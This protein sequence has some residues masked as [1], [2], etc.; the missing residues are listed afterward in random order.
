MNSH[1]NHYERNRDQN[2]NKNNMAIKTEDILEYLGVDK[3][4][5]SIEKFKETFEPEFIRKKLI[6][7]DKEIVSQITG[8]ALGSLTTKAKSIAKKYGVEL[9][10]DEI[11]DKKVE[12]IQELAFEKLAASNLSAVNELQAKV[13]QGKDDAVK[14]WEGKYQKLESKF[15]DTSKLHATTLSEFTAFKE[16]TAGQIKGIKLATLKD[17]AFG[18][19]KLKSNISDIEKAGFNSIVQEKY[20]FDLDEKGE[21]FVADKKGERIKSEKV[22]GTFKNID[23][24][25]QE[26]A[27]KAN[28]YAINPKGGAPAPQQGAANMFSAQAPI[29]H[30]NGIKPILI[31]RRAMV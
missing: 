22:T 15:N 20:S 29:Q 28:V 7:E 24:V 25:L 14:E 4:T 26:E 31:N 9:S 16:Q 8:K 17:A 5:D 1:R 13:G 2:Q 21:L 23:E 6:A 10:A 3:S 12:E 27:I 18:K 19:L 30:Q 11:K